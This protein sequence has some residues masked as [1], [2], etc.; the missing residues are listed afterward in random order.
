MTDHHIFIKLYPKNEKEEEEHIKYLLSIIEK[1]IED[2]KV[3]GSVSV[4]GRS[5]IPIKE[6][7]GDYCKVCYVVT[8][9]LDNNGVC[10]NCINIKRAEDLKECLLCGSSLKKGKG[11]GKGLCMKCVENEIKIMEML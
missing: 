5:L 9:D 7:N 3:N 8:R 6:F 10:E 4:E 2:I 1:G 11:N